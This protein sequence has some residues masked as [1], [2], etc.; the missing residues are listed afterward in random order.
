MATLA[1]PKGHGDVNSILL[2]RKGGGRVNERGGGGEGGEGDVTV[3][4]K[5]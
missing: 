5:L 4:G 2:L 3:I 1:E